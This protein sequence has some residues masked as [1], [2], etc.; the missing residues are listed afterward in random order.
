MFVSFLGT[1]RSEVQ[2]VSKG[3]ME[4]VGQS[5]PCVIACVTEGYESNIVDCL[6]RAG[7]VAYLIPRN[8]CIGAVGVDRGCSMPQKAVLSN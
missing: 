8:W 7:I 3:G 4:Q 1:Y 5:Y 6:N 2:E